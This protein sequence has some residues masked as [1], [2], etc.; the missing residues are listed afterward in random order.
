M[1]YG[2]NFLIIFIVI[3]FVLILIPFGLDQFNQNLGLTYQYDWLSF[4][5]NI[6][7]SIVTIWGIRLTLEYDEK[8]SLIDKKLEYRPILRFSSKCF[9]DEESGE[10]RTILNDNSMSDL[11]KEPS[12]RQIEKYRELGQ[13]K[14]GGNDEKLRRE[15]DELSKKLM[16]IFYVQSRF[17]LCIENVS[18]SV[19]ILDKIVMITSKGMSDDNF[20]KSRLVKKNSSLDIDMEINFFLKKEDVD[21]IESGIPK[22]MTVRVEFLDLL[23]NRY[24][25]ALCLQ[26]I[27]IDQSNI[28]NR[29]ATIKIDENTILV[30]PMEL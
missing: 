8:Q 24:C 1:K 4:Y 5:G 3:L 9:S 2:R 25:Y 18:D 30:E 23:R 21:H 28:F 6:L 15:F 14:D 11:C 7:G 12:I 16:N 17:K 10:Y 26:V 13:N 20:L 22:I 19:A 27:K 29:I